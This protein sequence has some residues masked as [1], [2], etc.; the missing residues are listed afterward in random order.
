MRRAPRA[1]AARPRCRRGPAGRGR[2]ARRRGACGAP[3]RARPR[4]WAP[5]AAGGLSCREKRRA[6][7][8]GRRCPRRGRARA[9]S[10][11]V[12]VRLHQRAEAHDC[13]SSS[14]R[15]PCCCFKWGPKKMDQDEFLQKLEQI[16]EQAQ[17]T[18]AEFPKTLTKERQRMIIALVRY[19]RSEA[20][21]SVPFPKVEPEADAL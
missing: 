12:V 5:P 18:L 10:A 4:H 16:E 1:A 17:L 6:C 8:P 3:P 2:A 14:G 11:H 7:A 20:E 19:I 21:R 13:A 9:C 15:L